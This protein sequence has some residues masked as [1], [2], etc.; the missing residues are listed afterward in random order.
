MKHKILSRFVILALLW[1]MIPDTNLNAQSD[2]DRRQ[3]LQS[4]SAEQSA[5][6]QEARQEVLEYAEERGIDIRK[7]LDDG[8]VMELMRFDDGFPVYYVTQNRSSAVTSS[9]IEIWPGGETGLELTG[10]G[11]MLGIWEGGVPDTD[12]QEFTD[13]RLIIRDD[14][15]SSD[16]A[17]HV[18]G[19]MIAA[20]EEEDAQGMAHEGELLAYTW[21]NTLSKMADAADEDNLLVANHSWGELRGWSDR[22]DPGNWRW[23]GDPDI[24]ETEDYMFGFYSETSQEWDELANNAPE[25]V[26]V[27]SAGNTRL[28]GPDEQPA[29]HEVWDSDEEDW[30]TSTTE[31]DLDGAPHGYQTIGSKSTAKNVLSVGAVHPIEDGYEQPGDVDLGSFSSWGPTDDG[32]VKPDIVAQGTNVYSPVTGSSSYGTMQGTSMSAPVVSG[33]VALLQEL[34]RDL[35][36]EDP[37]SATIRALLFH[38]VDQAGFNEGPDY[39]FGW[40]LMNAQRAAETLDAASESNSGHVVTETELEEGQTYEYT[41][42][43]D[44]EGPLQA[45]LAWTDPEGD[46]PSPQLNPDDIMLVNDLDLRIEGPNGQNY[47]PFILDPDNPD[48]PAT[49]GDNIRDNA[50]KVLIEDTQ[51]GEYIVKVTHKGNLEDGSQ[52]FSLIIS[53]DVE[54]PLE[55]PFAGGMGTEEDPYQIATADQLAEVGN[56]MGNHFVVTADIDAASLGDLD[57]IGNYIPE[58]HDGVYF[59]NTFDGNGHVISNLSIHNDDGATGMFAAI[60]SSAVIKNLTLENIQVVSEG[61]NIE[62]GGLAGRIFGEVRDV[63]VTGS[64][65]SDGNFVGG[66]VGL[67]WNGYISNSTSGVNVTGQAGTGGIL[68]SN[69][70]GGD[71][72]LLNSHTTEHANVSGTSSVGGVLG[73]NSDGTV[74]DV[75]N[76]ANV[77]GS[78]HTVGGII[79][80]NSDD[81]ENAYNTGDVEAESFNL[82]GIVGH[83]SG[84]INLVFNSGSF[85]AESPNAAGIVGHNSS[86]VLEDAYNTGDGSTS[87]RAGGAVGWNNDGTLISSYSTGF[88]DTG[89]G[90]AGLVGDNEGTINDS[91]WDIDSRDDDDGVGDG[92]TDGTEGLAED[93]ITGA[94]AQDNM[95]GLDFADVW[96]T[97]EDGDTEA[98]ADGYPILQI[99]D[100]QQQIDAQQQQEPAIVELHQPEDE[101]VSVS[102]EPELVWNAAARADTYHLQVSDEPDFSDPLVDEEELTDTYYQLDQEL[103]NETTYY[104]QVR[105]NNE[106]GF[107][108]W[109]EAWS[110]TT[111]VDAPEIV[112]LEA[113]EEESTGIA[114]SPELQWNESERAESYQ[115]RIAEDSGFDSIVDDISDISGISTSVDE[116][117][118]NST[119]YWKVRAHNSGGESEWSDAW[120]FATEFGLDTPVLAHPE[121]GEEEISVPA[122]LHWHPVEEAVDYK[123]QV[124]TDEDFD[125]LLELGDSDELADQISEGD[126]KQSE[127]WT[128]SQKV[129]ALDFNSEYYWRVRAFN[130]DLKSDWSEANS[131][132]TESAPI[133]TP[134]TLDSPDDESSEVPFPVELS[135]EEFE[136]ADN[137]DIQ[138]SESSEFRSV[139][140]EYEF[141]GTSF[142]TPDLKDTTS[143]YWRVRATV[144]GEKSVWSEV[145]TFETAFSGEEITDAPQLVSPE[146]EAERKALAVYLMWESIVHA[147][148]YDVEVATDSLFDEVIYPETEQLSKE[149]LDYVRL[150]DESQSEK[151]TVRALQVDDLDYHTTYYWRV[152]G[153][154]PN[155]EGDW[156]DVYSFSTTRDTEMGPELASPADGEDDL[157]FPVELDWQ[158]YEDAAHYDLQISE[159]PDFG[160]TTT[161]FSY[162]QTEFS[163]SD[164]ADTTTY[165]WR[166]RATVDEQQ[167]AWSEVKTFTTGIEDPQITDAPELDEPSDQ[168]EDVEFPINLSWQEFDDAESYDLEVSR[169]ADFDTLRAVRDFEGTSHEFADLADSTHY[170]WRVRASVDGQKSAWSEVWS[171]ETELRPPEVPEW[172]PEDGADGVETDILVEWSGSERAETYNLQLAEDEDFEELVIDET[173]IVDTEFKASELSSGTTYFWRV[174][175]IN[176]VGG[177]GWSE[178]LSLSTKDLVSVDG[179]GEVPDEFALGDN[180]PNPFN[181]DTRIRYDLPEQANVRLEVY[182]ILGE[183]VRTLVDQ[184]QQAGRYEITF[185]ASNLSSGTYIYRIEA[186]NFVETKQMM[187]VK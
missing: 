26:M 79:G 175:A 173:D 86:G 49:T 12:H 124:A 116:L 129:E 156:S 17:T 148:E 164:L 76:Y 82:G 55:I 149:S 88:T 179:E 30:V 131:L 153:T 9:V 185:D 159:A 35:H 19:T 64:V 81:L 28:S 61:E 171:F 6:W 1:A 97:V 45:T 87:D 68:G 121:E 105:A 46:P 181:P 157:D 98:E 50:E 107:G 15:S 43:S 178:S 65:E 59:E 100:R 167:T 37:K 150:S 21:S 85:I 104:W 165:Y 27:N 120:S 8:R 62:T 91:Y 176:E 66:I 174:E 2:S 166:V 130:D 10:D 31:R 125:K 57:P 3:Q 184:S 92:S 84:S 118:Y 70:G 161:V 132:T 16:H 170:F 99:L 133:S 54:A 67:S 39:R 108:D 158:A 122:Y 4:F 113:P 180:Y 106:N 89:T 94:A 162:D 143:Y 177:S 146:D 160:H 40:G 47:E 109:S 128:I 126:D 78:S 96:E 51:E 111:T 169:S 80:S 117:K 77:S 74:A 29:S 138:I 102:T 41:I 33:A 112:E 56:F 38:T 147:E 90:T 20:G 18:G 152:R 134:V 142:S 63:H 25:L 154:N 144:D 183:H 155:S 32:R 115:L 83:N 119:Y 72:E 123:L 93:E 145:R 110:F 42:T 73:Q 34:Y 139:Q 182:N 151:E 5:K 141:E 60:S 22:H 172:K 135:W 187:F 48:D 58:S 44:G 95:A 127:D 103:E 23:H 13:D 140:A 69:S 137:Y 14:V 7:E 36:K 136:D 53:D 71:S 186:G 114:V 101:A 24:S 168:A 75:S 11:Q 52:P 163:A